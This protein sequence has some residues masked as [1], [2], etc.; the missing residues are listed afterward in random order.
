M[1]EVHSV[2]KKI[3][4]YPLKARTKK[5]EFG[6]LSVYIWFYACIRFIRNSLRVNPSTDKSRKEKA[7]KNQQI[8]KRGKITMY[9]IEN[10]YKIKSI[11]KKS[12]LSIIIF[13]IMLTF[14]NW[15][16]ISIRMIIYLNSID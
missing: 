9:Y 1:T 15:L 3:I 6:I 5:N 2:L 14:N 7:R 11:H 8:N 4:S 10:Y 13:P 12:H 16:R